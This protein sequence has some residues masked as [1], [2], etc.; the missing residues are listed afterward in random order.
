MWIDIDGMVCM[1]QNENQRHF[2]WEINCSVLLLNG[3]DYECQY[4]IPASLCLSVVLIL[5]SSIYK[6]LVGVILKCLLDWRTRLKYFC[7]LFSLNP[8]WHCSALSVFQS[9]QYLLQSVGFLSLFVVPF[10]APLSLGWVFV[11]KR[12]VWPPAVVSCLCVQ[13]RFFLS[14]NTNSMW[15]SKDDF[16]W[17]LITNG[18]VQQTGAPPS[19]PSRHLQKMHILQRTL[20]G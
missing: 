19:S 15:Q 7:L 1:L 5:F 14:E 12:A 2:A 9:A 3:S 6:N 4:K 16:T 18:R 20:M 11:D 8:S 13:L 17:L 10:L